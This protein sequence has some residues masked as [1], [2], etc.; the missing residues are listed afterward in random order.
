MQSCPNAIGSD[1]RL[2]ITG[3]WVLVDADTQIIQLVCAW[4][5]YV[6]SD[7]YAAGSVEGKR[8]LLHRVLLGLTDPLIIGDHRNLVRLDNRLAN[9]RVAT[10]SQNG[11]NRPKRADNTS[12]YKGVYPCRQTGR[13]RAEIRAHRVC[14]KLGRF[15]T[16]VQAALAYDRAA[17]R[18]HGEFARTNFRREDYTLTN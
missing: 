6:D 9:L 3:G 8:V 2:P 5:W 15:D 10:K 18:L 11:F 13:W 1:I 12:G 14:H 17:I 7:G 16:P 4:S